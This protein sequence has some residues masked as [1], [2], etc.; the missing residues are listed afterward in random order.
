[1]VRLWMGMDGDGWD[2]YVWM[3]L[4]HVGGEVADLFLE[5]ELLVADG[6]VELQLHDDAFLADHRVDDVHG[7]NGERSTW[8]TT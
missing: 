7:L 1:M 4:S 8:W 2:G 3:R 5:V 6:V